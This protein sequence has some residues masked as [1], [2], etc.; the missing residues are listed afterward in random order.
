M[1]GQADSVPA[2]PQDRAGATGGLARAKAFWTV[3]AGVLMGERMPEY[4]KQWCYTSADYE[5]DIENAEKEVSET[6]FMRM[7]REA[8]EY[9]R[10]ITNPSR[11]NWVRVEFLWV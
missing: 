5:R 11:V 3:T 6:N 1:E 9:A 4:S 10:S 2:Q 7:D 8:H